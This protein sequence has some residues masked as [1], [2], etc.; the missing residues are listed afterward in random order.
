M[1]K[2]MLILPLL[3]IILVS[4][5]IATTTLNVPVAGGNYSTTLAVNCTTDQANTLNASI[6]YNASG[7][8]VGFANKLVTI[9]NTTASQTE[10]YQSVSISSLS[11][12]TTYNFT[13]YVDSGSAQETSA[14]SYP[15]T[16]DNTDPS[17]SIVVKEAST[18][19]GRYVTYTTSLSDATSGLDGTE[20]CTATDPEGTSHSLST[21]ASGVSFE[22][23][24]L[25]SSGTWTF[26]CTATDEAGNTA[27]S[28]DT[29][30]VSAQG[31][32]EV[33][34]GTSN[35]IVMIVAVIVL[36]WIIWALFKK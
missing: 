23:D 2:Q 11:D 18:T 28:T 17:V 3:A 24:R 10:F 1:N 30:R 27:T 16:I 4:S 9:A 20:T 6:Y 21:S 32:V 26:S 34:S 7:G 12:A 31:D 19:T 35:N 5:V 8:A 15:V 22:L 13:C 14:S 29:V 36:I 25:I 33:V